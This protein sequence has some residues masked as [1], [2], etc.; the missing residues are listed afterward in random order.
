M[1]DPGPLTI[2]YTEL[3][4]SRPGSPLATEWDVYRRE[5]GR[6][7]EEGNEG[8]HVLI[9]NEEIIGIFDT[10]EAAMFEGYKRYLRGPFLVHEIQ[11]REKL[12]R[13]RPWQL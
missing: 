1:F 10:H 5:A 9:K 2:H 13:L 6:L 12:L 4:P 11:T 8:R 3:P 7:I